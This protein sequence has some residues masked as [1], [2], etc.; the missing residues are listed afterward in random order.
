MGDIS[1]LH[2]KPDATLLINPTLDPPPYSASRRRRPE[3]HFPKTPHRPA[4]RPA[5]PR[6]REAAVEQPCHM[7]PIPPSAVYPGNYLSVRPQPA[8]LRGYH[9]T[10]AWRVCIR[11]P[12]HDVVCGHRPHERAARERNLGAGGCAGWREVVPTEANGAAVGPREG[13]G[14]HVGGAVRWGGEG[15]GKEGNGE[16]GMSVAVGCPQEI[17]VQVFASA[18]RV[19]II[20]SAPFRVDTFHVSNAV[21]YHFAKH[22]V[23]Q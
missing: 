15:K 3:P 1:D 4:Y 20:L 5:R 22:L 12:K 21:P 6:L 17:H 18:I 2:L 19:T 13:C 23:F 9:S 14:G 8:P 16:G 10:A 7:S 11:D